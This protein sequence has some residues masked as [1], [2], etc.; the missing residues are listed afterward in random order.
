MQ[1]KDLPSS[2][3]CCLSSQPAHSTLTLQPHGPCSAHCFLPSY[4]SPRFSVD[5][6]GKRRDSGNSATRSSR[7][8]GEPVVGQS[9][10]QWAPA[11]PTSPTS[12]LL[13][14]EVPEIRGRVKTAFER[15][16]SY[17]QALPNAEPEQAYCSTRTWL[18]QSSHHFSR[19]LSSSGVG[20]CEP[21]SACHRICRLGN[22]ILQ[23]GS[24]FH[25]GEVMLCHS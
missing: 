5:S 7:L 21:T 10:T 14:P 16:Q 4:S 13:S 2:S 9:M 20:G 6:P 11:S 17:A 12:G 1:A 25:L 22:T 23:V 18:I 8:P 15:R 24:W 19:G 3:L